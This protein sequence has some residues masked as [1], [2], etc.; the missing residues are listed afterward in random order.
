MF[1]GPTSTLPIV[2]PTIFKSGPPFLM[3]GWKYILPYPPF[4]RWFYLPLNKD[5]PL[6]IRVNYPYKGWMLMKGGLK[7]AGTNG[8]RS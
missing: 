3:A 6:F 4:K 2:R 7:K 8:G 1:D 5:E